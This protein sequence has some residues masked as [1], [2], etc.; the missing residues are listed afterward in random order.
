MNQYRIILAIVLSGEF[1]VDRRSLGVLV[2]GGVLDAA[3]VGFNRERRRRDATLAFGIFAS[4]KWRPE[5]ALSRNRASS[6][7][8]VARNY[9]GGTLATAGRPHRAPRIG[10]SRRQEP[11]FLGK[12]GEQ[13][14]ATPYGFDQLPRDLG[15]YRRAPPASPDT[16]FARAHPLADVVSCVNDYRAL[17]ALI[18][19]PLF[20]TAQSERQAVL[21]NVDVTR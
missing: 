10:E 9:A 8:P 11:G 20:H 2:V 6:G 19:N 18:V 17:H 5:L 21:P 7:L 4:H 3:V 1:Y 14:G 12:V 15:P 16:P 13:K